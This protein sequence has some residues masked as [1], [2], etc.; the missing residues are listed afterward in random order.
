MIRIYPEQLQTQL[1]QRLSG[2]YLLCGTEP[3]LLYES[4][5]VIR[6]VAR[7]QQFSEHSSI[8]LD[9]STDWNT[10]YTLCQEHGLFA[11]RQILTLILPE[12]G[13]NTLMAD[14]L[15]KL[16]TLLHG[17]ILL[18]IQSNKLNNAQENSAW[19]KALDHHAV[20]VRCGTPDHTQLPRWVINRAKSMQLTLDNAAC[21]LLCYCYEG[22]L[23]ALDQA[24][25]HLSLLW[26]D[27]KLTLPRVQQVVNNAAHFTPFQWVDSLLAGKS[28][29]ALHILRQMQS[30]EGDI[31]IMIRTLQRDLLLLLTLQR[32]MSS[33]P[34]RTLFDKYRLWQN[35]R[36]L[37]TDALQRIN[38]HLLYQA[39][40]RLTHIEIALKKEYQPSLWAALE[41]VS[42]LLCQPTTFPEHFC[43]D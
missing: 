40:Q 22:N 36:P 32:Q 38:A 17:D 41:T 20:M 18:I 33:T 3:L 15:V 2:R 28:Q 37:F 23:L 27:S 5:I 4:Q 42:L 1:H 24:L 26:P 30:I 16:F 29:R 34:L 31:I 25:K 43:H 11:S 9:A 10:I 39:I 7:Q 8:S 12:K 14:Q 6:T 21:Q 13:P 19:F 35:R